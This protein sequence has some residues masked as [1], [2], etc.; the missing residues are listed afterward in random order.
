MYLYI[1]D[2][3]RQAHLR[4]GEPTEAV[5]DIAKEVSSCS[6]MELYKPLI[7]KLNNAANKLSCPT[8]NDFGSVCLWHYS[9]NVEDLLL[10]WN[11]LQSAWAR[12]Q[13]GYMNCAAGNERELRGQYLDELC[14]YILKTMPEKPRTP[15]APRKRAKR[16][17]VQGRSEITAKIAIEYGQFYLMPK[18]RVEIDIHTAMAGQENS[19]C[20]AGDEGALVFLTAS[21]AGLVPVSLVVLDHEPEIA[22]QWQDIVEVSLQVTSSRNVLREWGGGKSYAVALP[23]DTYRVRYLCRNCD[24]ALNNSFAQ[25]GPGESAPDEYRIEMWPSPLSKDRVVKVGSNFL[26]GLV[27]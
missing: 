25:S 18:S 12:A 26:G 27:N 14:R 17:V 7:K 9:Q 22:D 13:K 19:I 23:A 20:G 3:E 8:G 6:D 15:G 21:Q 5:E 10:R 24:S 4:L 1:L 2:R 11:M 16:G